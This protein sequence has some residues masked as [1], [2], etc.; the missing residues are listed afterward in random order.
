MSGKPCRIGLERLQ[1]SFA[2]AFKLSVSVGNSAKRTDE[3]IRNVIE[4]LSS[5]D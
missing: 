3:T 5:R 4:E 1:N 2:I